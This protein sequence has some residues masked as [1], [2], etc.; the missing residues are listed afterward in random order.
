MCIQYATHHQQQRLYTLGALQGKPL[1]VTDIFHT[2]ECTVKSVMSPRR[3]A[4]VFL[5]LVFLPPVIRIR[6]LK[7]EPYIFGRLSTRSF[8]KHHLVVRN[9]QPPYPS[10]NKSSAEKRLHP[11][12][13]SSTLLVVRTCSEHSKWCKVITFRNHVLT[14]SISHDPCLAPRSRTGTRQITP[15]NST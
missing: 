11:C 8:R 2:M 12:R 14:C 5:A 3:G 15:A 13:T 7:V 4:I 9:W 10:R 1:H 6:V